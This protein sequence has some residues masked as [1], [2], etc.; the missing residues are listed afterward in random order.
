MVVICWCGRLSRPGIFTDRHSALFKTL[1]PLIA[2]RSALTVLLPICMVKQLKCFCKIFTM[3]AAKFHTHVLQALSLSLCHL[4]D[5]QLVHLLSSAYVAR[6]LML[7]AKWDKWQFVVKNWCYVL[8]SSSA[9]SE[10]LGA[11]FKKFC[12]FLNLPRKQPRPSA[13]TFWLLPLTRGVTFHPVT[14][15]ME[16][17]TVISFHATKPPAHTEVGDGVSS[18][19]MGEPSHPYTAVCLRKFRGIVY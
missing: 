15:Q 11:L 1:K 8:S 10:L 2:L 9:L 12:L 4:S 13:T 14:G 5:E 17:H 7:I 3:F 18:Q 19:N 16:I 6:R